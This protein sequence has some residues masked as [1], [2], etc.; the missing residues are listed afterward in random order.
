M[1]EP[2]KAPGREMSFAVGS[3]PRAVINCGARLL[4]TGGRIP[5]LWEFPSG[6]LRFALP[7]TGMPSYYADWDIALTADKKTLLKI[8]FR[9]W[10]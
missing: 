6:R 3:T 5:H 10:K 1:S 7:L 8:H 2:R 9:T 4:M